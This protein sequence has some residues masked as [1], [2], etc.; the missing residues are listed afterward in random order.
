MPVDRATFALL[1]VACTSCASVY[2]GPSNRV[3]P[4]PLSSAPFPDLPRDHFEP[5]PPGNDARYE[6]LPI[7]AGIGVAAAG[8]ARLRGGCFATCAYATV[9]NAKTGFCVPEPE[10]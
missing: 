8:I 3:D 7:V 10:K 1:F 2:V 4:P 5:D 6:V 9:C